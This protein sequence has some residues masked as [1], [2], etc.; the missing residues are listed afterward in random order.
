MEFVGHV[1]DV[2]AAHHRVLEMNFIPRGYMIPA[3]A[4]DVCAEAE[5]QLVLSGV[6]EN[7]TE[8]P[9]LVDDD[10]WHK[11]QDDEELLP[12]PLDKVHIGSLHENVDLPS[13]RETQVV[14]DVETPS[15]RHLHTLELD[16]R[17]PPPT[18]E[19]IQR[20]SAIM[21]TPLPTSKGVG[22][23]GKKKHAS[24]LTPTQED[25]PEDELLPPRKLKSKA[26]QD[27][28]PRKKPRG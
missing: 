28:R 18:K 5:S 7:K 10:E 25:H 6:A 8:P 22:S 1:D 17:K 16:V 20:V 11:S 23:K 2:I 12:L 27:K 21:Q 3:A 13:Q 26:K 4:R 15:A 14:S 9:S 24:P 19:L